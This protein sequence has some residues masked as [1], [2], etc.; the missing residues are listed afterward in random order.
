MIESDLKTIEEYKRKAKELDIILDLMPGI[1]A[2]KDSKNNF[3]RVNKYLAEAHN[4][5]KEEME[6]KSCFDIYP[7]EDAQKYWDDDLEIIKSG[8]PK[9]AIEEPWE[10][11]EGTR[12]LSTSKIPYIDEN[13]EAKGILGIAIDITERKKAEEKLRE[14]QEQLNSI[15]SN[16]KD[17]V[18][19]ISEDYKILF[20]NE[21]AHSI[22]GEDL[23]GR[24]CFEVIK[25]EEQVCDNCPIQNLITSDACQ[26]HSEQRVQSPKSDKIKIFDVITTSIEN[27][28]GEKAYL[29]LLRDITTRKEMEEVSARLAAIVENSDDAIIGKT[30]DGTI[31]SWNK[32]RRESM[33]THPKRS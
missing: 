21:N 13:G 28:N 8:K 7:S 9:L 29:E 24:N 32:V 12:W 22:F 17:T 4:M 27:Y 25:G 1:V 26:I 30:L 19:V 23:I 2:Y 11:E 15:F 3:I 16:L 20:K 10:S 31:L 33:V 6:G 18:F 14:S 5:T